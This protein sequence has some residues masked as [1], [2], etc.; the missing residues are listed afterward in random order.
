MST[1]AEIRLFQSPRGG[2]V[3]RCTFSF[4]LS[5]S[6][7]SPREGKVVEEKQYVK[8]KQ[9]YIQFQSPRG[10]KVVDLISIHREIRLV[11]IPQRG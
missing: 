1:L 5:S 10:G 3:E 8:E 4:I 11:S 6:S 9:G 7:Q 2:K